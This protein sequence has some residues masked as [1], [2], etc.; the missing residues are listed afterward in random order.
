MYLI[1]LQSRGVYSPQKRQGLQKAM[2]ICK[3]VARGLTR[4]CLLFSSAEDHNWLPVAP[5]V[6]V[7]GMEVENS[8]CNQMF[9]WLLFYRD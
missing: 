3:S 8:S 4:S 7:A 1:F 5:M 2:R 9:Y 6:I